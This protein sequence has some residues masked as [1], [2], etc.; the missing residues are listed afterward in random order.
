M[1]RMSFLPKL[2]P[3]GPI[4][5]SLTTS[6]K[7]TPPSPRP[8]GVVESV[9]TFYATDESYGVAPVVGAGVDAG[10]GV[11]ET[12]VAA[13]APVAFGATSASSL[14]ACSL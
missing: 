12:G 5:K 4:G 9:E 1:S 7:K 3:S 11:F 14:V 2:R 13:G 6:E 10:F 8:D